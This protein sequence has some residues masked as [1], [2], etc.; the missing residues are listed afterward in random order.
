MTMN[1]KVL[2]KFRLKQVI[3][4]NANTMSGMDCWQFHQTP[5]EYRKVQE[6]DMDTH[7]TKKI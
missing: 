5:L 7:I 6:Y 1:S 2:L 3:H 4:K